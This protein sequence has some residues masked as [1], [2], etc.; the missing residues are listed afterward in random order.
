MR[1]GSPLDLNLEASWSTSWRQDRPSETQDGPSET[2]M[3]NFA[4]IVSSL[5]KALGTMRRQQN[6]SKVEPVYEQTP[7]QPQSGRY[8]KH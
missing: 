8:V 7:D 3:A 1:F 5:K 4:F 2:Q 6:V